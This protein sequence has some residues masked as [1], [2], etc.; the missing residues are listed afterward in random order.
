[1]V[2]VPILRGQ[3]FPTDVSCSNNIPTWS[4]ASQ[5][6]RVVFISES[7]YYGWDSF[8]DD[9]EVL[10]AGVTVA[11]LDPFWAVT[12]GYIDLRAKLWRCEASQCPVFFSGR[13][14]FQV[15][16]EATGLGQWLRVFRK[17]PSRRPC[18]L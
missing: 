11:G 3:E 10:D 7:S 9:A 13:Q 15:C 8:I 4:W 5:N 17:L 2:Q 16:V 14:R 1:M 6:S 12:A 18:E